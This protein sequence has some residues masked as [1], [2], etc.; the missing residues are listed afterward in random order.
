MAIKAAIFDFDDTLCMSEASCF[1]L[2]NEIL[3]R[4]GR[5]AQPRELHKNTWGIDLESAMKLRSPGIDIPEFWRLFPLVHSEFVESGRMDVVPETN[6][7]ALRRLKG[8]GLELMIVTSRTETESRH[9]RS[10][11]HK[12]AEL[13]DAFYHKDSNPWSKPDPRVFAHIEHQ[14]GF[15]PHECVYVGD[16]IGDAAAATGAGLY[17]IA[18]LEGGLL[19]KEDFAPYAV[20]AFVSTFPEVPDVI[21]QLSNE[22]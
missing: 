11:S 22:L 1:A 6:L 2:E 17:F 7:A 3:R 21:L 20:D 14:H 9:L 8:M 12:L 13:I 19:A 15:K 4:M 10:S 16:A 5:D 18:S